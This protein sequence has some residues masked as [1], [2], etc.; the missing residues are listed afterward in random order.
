MTRMPIA[1]SESLTDD[2]LPGA[3]ST[4]P[5]PV[6]LLPAQYF[7]L[8]PGR[9]LP[10]GVRKLLV[11]ILDDAI[12][13]Y[14]KNAGAVTRDRRR[15]HLQARRWLMSDDRTWVFSFLRVTE[16]LGIDA[17]R[18]RRALRL[19]RPIEAT[20]PSPLPRMRTRPNE[21]YARMEA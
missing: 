3:Q 19:P 10:T 4:R 7:D 6:A 11:A 18:V 12:N 16:A 15:V 1:F 14:R 13:A 21:A 5:A 20:R 2:A 17:H 8:A 9:H